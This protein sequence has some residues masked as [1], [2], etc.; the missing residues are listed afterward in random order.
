MPDPLAPEAAGQGPEKMV[1]VREPVRQEEE[2]EQEVEMVELEAQQ[3]AQQVVQLA[4]QLGEL[5]RLEELVVEMEEEQAQA[6]GMKVEGPGA[7]P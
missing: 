2:P 7:L 5:G 6:E 1:E 3:A 4:V